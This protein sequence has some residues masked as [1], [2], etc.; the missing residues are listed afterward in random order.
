MRVLCIGDSLGLPREDCP[1]ETT[2][3]YLLKE[4]FKK[5]EFIDFFVRGL[6]I[7]NALHRYDTYFQFYSADLAIIQTGIVD[8]APRYI[9]ENKK[10]VKAII[11]FFKAL[12]LEC[13]FWKMVKRGGRKR[14]CVYTKPDD[15]YRFYTQL[16]SQ[17]LG[18]GIKRVI[19]VKIGHATGDVLKSN[20]FFNLN[21][22][23]YN[24]IL[25]RIRNDYPTVVVT[26]NPL[27]S[28]EEDY[29]VDG[30]HCNPK[31]MKKVYE[32]LKETLSLYGVTE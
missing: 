8:C 32:T 29:F 13:L 31:G 12:G 30:Y 14:S 17:L 1:Y 20:P 10:S 28:V 24:K 22:D 11:M 18:G 16:V 9:R 3:Y 26:V 15:F 5:Y 25:D 6:E 23:D 7:E 4:Y 2:W 21:V 19:I 27:E